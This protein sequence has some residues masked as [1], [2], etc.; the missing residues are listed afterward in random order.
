MKLPNWYFTIIINVSHLYCQ[1][2]TLKLT[3]FLKSVHVHQALPT[4]LPYT[5]LFTKQPDFKKA[6]GTKVLKYGTKFQQAL[7][8]NNLFK[9]LKYHTKIIYWI[10]TSMYY[11]NF[12]IQYKTL[13]LQFGWNSSLASWQRYVF[14]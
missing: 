5:F 3:K 4:I 6:S 2:F 10:C 14:Y 12:N 7:K 11:K 1:T 9:A 13:V 8:P